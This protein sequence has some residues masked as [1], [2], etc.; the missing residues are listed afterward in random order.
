MIRGASELGG[1]TLSHVHQSS[2]VTG[3]SHGS[4]GVHRRRALPAWLS[5][6]LAATA[7]LVAAGPAGADTGTTLT[8]R[9]DVV[10]MLPDPVA[11]AA[12]DAG[13][14]RPVVDVDGTL[15]AVPPALVAEALAAPGDVELT[16]RADAGLDREGAVAALATGGP[17]AEVVD[18]SAVPGTQTQ[19]AGRTVTGVHQVTVVPV[20]WGAT[21]GTGADALASW[22]QQT[23]AYWSD[24]S[25]GRVALQVD[26]RP[27]ARIADP[28]SCDETT[29][30]NAAA[31]AAGIGSVDGFHHL[32]VYFPHRNDCGWDGLATIGSGRIWINGTTVTDVFSHEFGHNLG[33]GHANTARCSSGGARVP[34]VLP[35]SGCALSEYGDRA[36]VMGIGIASL[37]TGNLTSA[38]AD[39]LGLA[40]VLRASPGSTTTIALPPLSSVS[41][42]RAV[43]VP[44]PGGTVYV[45][46]RPWAGRDQRASGWAGVQ[47]HLQVVQGTGGSAYPVTYLL[48]MSPG[49]ATAFQSPALGSGGR[50]EV[51]GTGLAV[52]VGAVG[53]TATVTVAPTVPGSIP[54]VMS[55]DSPELFRAGRWFLRGSFTTGGADAAFDFAGPGDVPV[56]GDWDGNGSL[57]P[58]IFRGGQWYLRQSKSGGVADVTFGFASPG[59]IPVVGDWDGDG[60]DTPGV[61]RGGMWYLRNSNT[62]GVADL[63]YAYGSPG[64]VPVVGDWDGDG[65]DTIGVVRGGRWF[66]TN[67]NG[68]GAAE[69]TYGFGQLGDVPLVG[70][71]DGDG[72]DGIGVFRGGHWYLT[73]QPGSGVA[74]V[75]FD[76][77][78]PGDVPLL[79]R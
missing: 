79:F 69:A 27:W 17:Q 13:A 41:A 48:D 3:P 76:F 56:S 8:V 16:V 11:G 2:Q 46:F 18:L 12:A 23:V 52:T 58:G 65:K 1:P 72:R 67:H 7:S 40:T 37:P 14:P 20:Y 31:A 70:D 21:D 45:D 42:T 53:A 39:W 26:V 57:T 28:G 75:G 19:A 15:V 29:I 30:M 66:L 10:T 64:D 61:F 50:W 73:N 68:S 54:Q 25:A 35:V 24:Q 36:D 22:A 5:L 32:A 63:T 78:S 33:L 60:V 49:T 62:S 55:V 43:A 74:Q 4:R 9:G 38:S 59:D 34:L 51:P 77:G 71:W 44:V 47:V 6:A